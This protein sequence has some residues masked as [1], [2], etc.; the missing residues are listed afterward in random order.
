MKRLALASFALLL[1]CPSESSPP[2]MT[3]PPTSDQ[4]LADY[5]SDGEHGVGVR[6]L[7]LEDLTRS[8]PAADGQEEL[9]SRSLSVELWYPSADGS[10]NQPARDSDVLAGPHPLIVFSHGFM[11]TRLDS[12]KL[13]K[14]LAS[15]GYV[16][17]APEFPLSS[18]NTTADS[19]DSSDV[20][21]QP[22]DVSFILDTLLDD[23]DFTTE[24]VAAGGISLGGLTTLLVGLTP[25]FADPRIDVLLPLTPA[26]CV[27]PMTTFS[28]PTLPLLLA[29]GTSDAI[30]PYEGHVTPFWEASEGPRRLVSYAEGT[31]TGFAD[32]TEDLL[33]GTDHADSL[34]CGQLGD[35]LPD[36]PTQGDPD[37]LHPNCPLPCVNDELGIGMRP[38][39]Q[40]LL[41]RGIAH[42]FLDAEFLSDDAAALW[43][44]AGV[45]LQNP[46]V[47]VHIGM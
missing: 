7:Y 27:L 46:D 14:H 39:R 30:L 33:D 35:A 37:S 21:N 12:P 4:S 32:L 6:T 41:T 47:D 22:G 24:D 26:T 9:P 17:A 28:A 10:V 36:E 16:F 25:E 18:R 15:H 8:T 20:T 44:D 40:G 38:T 5:A 45:G 23:P 34:G 29:H 1:A 11:S 2:E 42:A 13:G 43:L 31:H 19:P 3:P